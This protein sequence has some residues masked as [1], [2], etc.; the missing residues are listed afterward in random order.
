MSSSLYLGTPVALLTQHGKETLI[1]DPLE[2]ALGCR[3]VHT[4]AFDTDQLGTFTGDVARA[5]S[6]RDAARAKARMGMQLTGAQVGLASEG[7]FGP[8]PFDGFMPW[9]TELLLWVDD[10]HGWEVVGMAHGPARHA[11][12][13]VGTVAE[14]HQLAAEAGFPE[15]HLVLR[16]AGVADAT[17]LHKG[18]HTPDALAAAFDACRHA[19]P[20]GRVLAESDLRAFANP[21]RQKLIRQALDDLI[22]RLQSACPACGAPGYWVTERLPGLPCAACHSPT[23]LPLAEVWRCSAC[24]HHEQRPMAAGGLA[25]PMRCDQCNP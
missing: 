11:Q 8:D 2:A 20:Q 5:G 25:D 24:S 1:R 14:L 3:L 6:Q 12:R 7:A 18:L 16:P 19:S 17:H 10:A 4:D 9:D 23:R 13:E 21:T 15:H 22:T